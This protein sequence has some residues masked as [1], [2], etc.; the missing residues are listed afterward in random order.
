MKAA[1]G[2]TPALKAAVDEAQRLFVAGDDD[3]LAAVL[4]PVMDGMDPQTSDADPV[5]AHA[6]LLLLTQ[7]GDM[8]LDRMTAWA[9]YA[10]T[11]LTGCD[12]YDHQVAAWGAGI[13]AVL[14]RGSG[15]H[16]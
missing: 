11:T 12:D 4:H 3:A 9:R 8:P 1:N 5:L 2:S 13:W 15:R 7:A 10:H 14:L 16:D 6:A